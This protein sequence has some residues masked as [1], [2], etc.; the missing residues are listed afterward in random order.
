MLA[1]TGLL[2]LKRI[3]VSSYEIAVFGHAT[4]N[5]FKLHICPYLHQPDAVV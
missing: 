5:F 1:V 4:L 3:Q 2:R